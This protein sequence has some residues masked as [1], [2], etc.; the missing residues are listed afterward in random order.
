[1]EFRHLLQPLPKEDFS[2]VLNGGKDQLDDATVPFSPYFGEDVARQKPTHILVLDLHYGLYSHVRDIEPHEFLNTTYDYYLN[3]S[4]RARGERYLFEVQQIS[5]LQFHRPGEHNLIFVAL[6]LSNGSPKAFRNKFLKRERADYEERMDFSSLYPGK[7]IHAGGKFVKV[8]GYHEAVI[9]IP[10]DFF[11][12]EPET[13]FQKGVNNW[14]NWLYKSKPIDECDYRNRAIWAFTVK[15]FLWISLFVLRLAALLI[16]TPLIFLAGIFGILIGFQMRG[17]VFHDLAVMWNHFLFWR[18]GNTFDSIVNNYNLT[19]EDEPYYPYKTLY[20]NKK[21]VGRLPVT[22]VGLVFGFGIVTLAVSSMVGLLTPLSLTGIVGNTIFGIAGVVLFGHWVHY[23]FSSYP[24]MSG[25][26]SR[27]LTW[28][29]N[30]SIQAEEPIAKKILI[31]YSLIVGSA[32][33]LCA[34]MAIWRVTSISLSLKEVPSQVWSISSWVL[35]SVGL[36]FI[37]RKRI[38]KAWREYLKNSA[39]KATARRL[40]LQKKNANNPKAHKVYAA[41]KEDK[42]VTWLKETM[43]IQHKPAKVDTSMKI[44][45]PTV[46]KTM[47]TKF[48]ASFWAL[49]AQICRPYAKR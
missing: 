4:V 9:T 7:S 42:Y 24:L 22:L 28:L 2:I 34:L 47:V 39:E 16:A 32:F 8:L 6:D 15:P 29:E 14:V 33:V 20:W 25:Y 12:P 21:L 10:K 35:L 19:S 36:Y 45:G 5:H 18:P 38:S 1:M 48:K 41:P 49:K 43:N 23:V 27:K 46:S 13:P 40:E 17:W 30:M 44:T 3:E 31:R 37:L 11:A 26:R